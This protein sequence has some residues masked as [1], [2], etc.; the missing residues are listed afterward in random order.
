MIIARYF[1]AILVLWGVSQVSLAED[2][3]LSKQYASCM[4]KADVITF[5]R[6]E[7]YGAESGRQ[8]VRLNKTYKEIMA[9]LASGRKKELQEVQ[10]AWI[11]YRDAKC[12]FYYGG[13][14][15]GSMEHEIGSSCFMFETALR[16]KELE[17]LKD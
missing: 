17:S 9:K 11:K 14:E 4:D 5:D 8:D 1:V 3:S 15:G 6:I 16:A 13:S 2:R 10:R 7:C 12:N